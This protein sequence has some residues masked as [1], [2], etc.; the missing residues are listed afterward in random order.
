M[1]TLVSN[2]GRQH[3][4]N[5]SKRNVR[6]ECLIPFKC[7]DGSIGAGAGAC[8]GAFTGEENEC[9]DLKTGGGPRFSRDRRNVVNF[10]VLKAINVETVH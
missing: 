4:R 10:E 8:A 1:L 6:N 9:C 3:I 7:C 5:K 2:Q